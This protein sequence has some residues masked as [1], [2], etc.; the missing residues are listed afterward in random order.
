MC[1]IDTSIDSRQPSVDVDWS[2]AE[3][4]F[5]YQMQ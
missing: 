4:S 5:R 2:R 1:A 3:P